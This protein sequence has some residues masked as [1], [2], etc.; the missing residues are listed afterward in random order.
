MTVESW[1]WRCAFWSSTAYP[2]SNPLTQPTT[3]TRRLIV[4]LRWLVWVGWLLWS[5]FG[6][7]SEW[8]QIAVCRARRSGCF[9][10]VRVRWNWLAPR[11]RLFS[12][13]QINFSRPP[14]LFPA[15]AHQKVCFRSPETQMQIIGILRLVSAALAAVALLLVAFRLWQVG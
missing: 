13:S 9:L 1:S 7:C 8:S 5:A 3:R 15:G 14:S 10:W 11:R 4:V 12:R 6:T 2:R